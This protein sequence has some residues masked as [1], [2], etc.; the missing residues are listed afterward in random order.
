MSLI[1]VFS[2]LH[3]NTP[4]LRAFLAEIDAVGPDLV[5]NLGD[6]AS[7]GVDPRGTMAL[8][9]TRPEILTVRGNHERQLTT[10]EREEMSAADQLAFDT[11][12]GATLDRLGALPTSLE[13]AP[14]VLAFHGSPADDLCYLLETVDPAVPGGLRESTDEEVLTRLGTHARR[15]GVYLCGHTHLQRI[16]RLPDGALVVNP[17]SLGW[18]AF[19]DSDP[20]PH[21]VEAGSPRAR[22]ALLRSTADGW[23]VSARSLEYDVEAAATLAEDHG[24]DDIA[25]A[26][27]TGRASSAGPSSRAALPLV[28]AEASAYLSADEVVRSDAPEVIALVHELRGDATDDVAFAKAAYTWVRDRVTHSVD[29]QDP[30]RTVSATEVLRHRTGVCFAKSHL[31]AALLRAGGVPA[32]LCYQRLGDGD[33]HVLH[34]LVAV[35]LDGRWHRIDARGNNAHVDARFTLYRERLAWVAD[36]AAGEV[37]YPQVFVRPAPEVVAAL[38]GSHDMLELCR[39][40]LPTALDPGLA[41][42]V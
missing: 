26:L 33:G 18:P 28:A 20:H 17:G 41:G 10:L 5:V 37:D 6:I 31:L 34:G 25:H 27:R 22:Y 19:A 30:R 36:P 3:G 1:A 24:R 38:R 4:A 2:D 9:A 12:D 42:R 7:G 23:E 14:G 11:L 40:G 35:H 29:A 32:G 16:R 8:L 13:I 39:T 15:Y 21:R